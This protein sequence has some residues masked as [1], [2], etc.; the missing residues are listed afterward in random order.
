MATVQDVLD[1]KGPDV[2]TLDAGATVLD[3]AQRMNERGIGGVVVMDAGAVVGIFT[4]RDILRRVVAKRRDPARTAV[5]EVMT[6]P[7]ITCRPEA[8]LDECR[9]LITDKR[10]RHLPV[11]REG[12]LCGIITSGD[13]LAQQVREQQDTIQHLHNYMFDVR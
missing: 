12:R 9:A 8:A 1:I 2:V 6:T 10:V 4:E 13:I 3:A 7:I 11:M 5:R